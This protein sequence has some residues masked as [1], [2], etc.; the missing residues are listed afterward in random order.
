MT[1]TPEQQPYKKLLQ[2]PKSK[3]FYRKRISE[4]REKVRN[5]IVILWLDEMERHGKTYYDLLAYMDALHLEACV[6]PIHDKDTWDSN[7]VL[8]WCTMHI[9]PETGDLSEDYIDD[10]PYVG[11]YKKPHI[12]LLIKAPSQQDTTW[13]SELMSGFIPDMKETRWDKCFS[14]SGSI[15]YWCHMDSPDK[16]RYSEW[17]IH[18]IAGIDMSCLSKRDTHTNDELANMVQDAIK[19]Y[20]IKYYHQL[21]DTVFELGDAE[22]TSYVRGTHALWRGYLHDKAQEIKDD[23][24]LAKMKAERKRLER[25]SS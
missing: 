4:T 1:N 22:L 17:E 11:K 8:D 6:S 15:R 21:L 19:F 24:Y 7:S 2:K 25:L 3:A 10:A 12:H 5:V 13:W 23:A 9:D 20:K 14:L 16:H 18:G